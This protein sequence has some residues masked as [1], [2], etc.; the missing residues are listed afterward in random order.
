M[1]NNVSRRIGG[2][3]ITECGVTMTDVVIREVSTSQHKFCAVRHCKGWAPQV[4]LAT[5]D[6]NNIVVLGTAGIRCHGHCRNTAGLGTAGILYCW[7]VQEHST[8]VA[9]G[10]KKILPS[11]TAKILWLWAL[12][13]CVDMGTAEILR[14]WA[15]QGYFAERILSGCCWSLQDTAGI[16][17]GWA[18][19]YLVVGQSRDTLRLVTAGIYFAVGHCRDLFCGWALQGCSAV[20]HCRDTLRLGTAETLGGWAPQDFAVVRCKD[21]LRLGI[22][23]TFGDRALQGC[24]AVGPCSQ[25]LGGGRGQQD[26]EI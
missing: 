15:L 16:P 12:Q 26:F 2:E 11:S 25:A 13:G 17:C 22:A 18:Q 21:T 20:E 14:R 4:D 3:N 9:V 7:A 6:C 8:A 1:K 24:S 5:G 19:G 23:G 10:H